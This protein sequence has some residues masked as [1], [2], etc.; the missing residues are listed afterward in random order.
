[1]G[2]A[3]QSPVAFWVQMYAPIW[4]ALLCGMGGWV[5]HLSSPAHL[6][7]ALLRLICLLTCVSPV[8]A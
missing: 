5:T 1:M 6:S 8:L 2:D 7:S 4:V 3:R